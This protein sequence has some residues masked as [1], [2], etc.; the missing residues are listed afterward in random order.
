M[1]ATI[2]DVVKNDF[3]INIPMSAARDIF[4]KLTTSDPGYFQLQVSIEMGERS[5]KRRQEAKELSDRLDAQRAAAEAAKPFSERHSKDECGDE[6]NRLRRLYNFQW[7]P[8]TDLWSVGGLI[9]HAYDGTW[10]GTSSTKDPRD[11]L[12]VIERGIE[13]G[14]LKEP[15]VGPLYEHSNE[16]EE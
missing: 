10:V 8:Q 15:F 13:Q 3:L 7:Q 14:I 6:F 4:A 2:A 5:E 9:V 12:K 16:D 1:T 11:C